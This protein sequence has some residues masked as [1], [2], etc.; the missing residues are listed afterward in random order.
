MVRAGARIRKITK[1]NKIRGG[2]VICAPGANQGIVPKKIL[3]N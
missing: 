1:K 2:G 3:Y